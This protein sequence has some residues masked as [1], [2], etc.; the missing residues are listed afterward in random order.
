MYNDFLNNQSQTEEKSCE[1]LEIEQNLKRLSEN[2]S[3]MDVLLSLIV[4][5]VYFPQLT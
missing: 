4:Y 2:V 5:F 3:N 1:H